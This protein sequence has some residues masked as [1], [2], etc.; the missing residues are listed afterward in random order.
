MLRPE[1]RSKN[2]GDFLNI[3]QSI[4]CPA[5]PEKQPNPRCTGAQRTGVSG[6]QFAPQNGHHPVNLEEGKP[7]EIPRF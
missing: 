1:R 6:T 5:S 2:G 3:G 4:V 7:E